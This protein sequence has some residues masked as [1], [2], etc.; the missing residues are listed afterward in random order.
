[1]VQPLTSTF[2]DLKVGIPS[3]RVDSF[4]VDVAN[5]VAK[6]KKHTLTLAPEAG[7]PAAAQRDQ[8][9]RERRG[10]L[11]AAENAFQ[12]GW[13]GVKMYFMVGL[14]TETMEDVDGHRRDGPEGEGD[15]QD[16]TSAAAPA[17]A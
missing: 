10:P 11:G 4:S 9:A 5:A 7:Q 15:R 14:P 12:R 1:M 3:T 2:A 16:A 17:C 13:T 8:Q 6:G